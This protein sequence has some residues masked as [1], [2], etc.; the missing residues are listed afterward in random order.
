MSG[1]KEI[2]VIR[3]RPESPVEGNDNLAREEGRKLLEGLIRGLVDYPDTIQVSYAVGDKTTVY[4]VECD[5][6]CLGQVIGSKGKNISGVRAV[7]SAT[8]AR[9]GIRAVVEIPYYCIDV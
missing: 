7:L 9:K 5:Q 4:R 8:M 2:K 6:R 3:K 1:L